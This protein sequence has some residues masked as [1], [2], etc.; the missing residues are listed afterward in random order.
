MPLGNGMGSTMYGTAPQRE[1]GIARIREWS[2]K[3]RVWFMPAEPIRFK[4]ELVLTLSFPLYLERPRN[5]TLRVASQT[6]VSTPS[7]SFSSSYIA[8]LSPEEVPT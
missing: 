6:F 4:S 7:L 1:N 2:Q 3:V 8:T 5:L